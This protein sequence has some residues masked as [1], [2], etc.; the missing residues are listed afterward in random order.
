MKAALDLGYDSVYV[1]LDEYDEKIFHFVDEA[2]KRQIKAVADMELIN[3]D[4]Y[5]IKWDK[6][7]D[8]L[9]ERLE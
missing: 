9:L 5:K 8:D 4:E 1:Y 3:D 2:I 6:F 7:C